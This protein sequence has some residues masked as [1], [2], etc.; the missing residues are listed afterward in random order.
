[1]K[2]RFARVSRPLAAAVLALPFLALG[3][4]A[5]AAA[6]EGKTTVGVSLLDMSAFMGP[7]S[8]MG[9]GNWTGRGWGG[10]G[11]VPGQGPGQGMGPG[12]GRGPGMGPG[13]GQ[14]PGMQ[15][16]GPG[17]GPGAGGGPGWGM[18]GDSM[19]GHGMMG[20]GMMGPG[21]GGM[22]GQGMMAVRLDKPTVKAGEVRFEV[23]NLSRAWRHEMVVVAVDDP[24]APLPYDY[25]TARVPE[26]KLKVLGEVDELE[27]GKSGALDVKL[28]PGSYLLICNLPGH[29]AAGMVAVFTVTP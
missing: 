22:M 3:P 11:M 17:Q 27:A 1:M 2:S 28:E 19:I 24:N 14:G 16:R 18:M 9:P 7:G 25:N 6:P 20:W 26:D 23:A 15:G 12:S 21:G 4:A 8:G 10:Q 5:P 29:Y 13:Q